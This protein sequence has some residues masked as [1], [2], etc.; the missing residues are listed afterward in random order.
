M[1]QEFVH[2][3]SQ[4]R[5]SG[6]DVVPGMNSRL[7]LVADNQNLYSNFR[8]IFGQVST[9]KSLPYSKVND[10]ALDA[11]ESFCCVP[12]FEVDYV[13]SGEAGLAVLQQACDVKRPYAVVFIDMN[14]CSGWS[15][16]K[17]IEEY[18]NVDRFLQC[19]LCTT[20]L[21][22]QWDVEVESMTYPEHL[23]IL[24][25]PF[26]AIDVQQ[27]AVV[28]THKWV[29][30]QRTSGQEDR[31]FPV[32]VEPTHQLEG[33]D[34]CLVHDS[35]HRR[36]DEGLNIQTAQDLE[37]KN[38]EL[39]KAKDEL[40]AAK[41]HMEN[42]IGSMA[43]TLLVINAD[44]T[45]EAVNR[46]LLMLLGY[47]EEELLQE[48]PSKIFGEEL[49]QGSIMEA[50][51][52][53]GVVSNVETTYLAKN[54]QAIPMAL[55]GSLMKDDRG[56]IQGLV[57]VAQN[58]TERKRLEDERRQFQDQLVETSRRLGMADVATSVLHN[59]GNVLNSINV[60]V[61]IMGTTLR[62]SLVGDVRKISHMLNAHMGDLNA[63]VTHDAKGR[64]VPGYLAQ[65]ADHLIEERQVTLKEL[66]SLVE[67]AEHAKQCVAM[68]Q[69]MVK[70]G[71]LHE[72]VMLV[73]LM[74]QALTI[75]KVLLEKLDGDI[76][77]EFVDTEKVIVDK[78]QTLQILVN[79]IRNSTQAMQ[80]SAHKT[81]TV[82][83]GPAESERNMVQL[84]V[85]DTGVGI[86][87]DQLTHI[88][89]QGFTTKKDGHGFGLH[90]GALLAKNM[91]GSLHV[92]SAG[93]G[94]GATFILTLPVALPPD[95]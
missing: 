50:L 71:G 23:L 42:I 31:A 29:M 75:N 67:S 94:C 59:V 81:L 8:R 14:A 48:C 61:G 28:L 12:C 16:K 33:V 52:F 20:T 51:Y 44:M 57:C 83:I 60:S 7:L 95:L 45:I 91:G 10:E 63:Y 2:V 55:S 4:R 43:D 85:T 38:S 39:A 17:T 3:S 53:Q 25:K 86:P 64:Q 92:R 66:D 78:H 30:S 21:D 32:A 88:F 26:H 15:R 13:E 93:E 70:A 34:M 5:M 73:D 49:T 46:S 74:E 27:L 11:S 76:V 9:A 68:Q 47:K 35:E 58:I 22:C 89:S 40:S 79:L 18:W 19:V 84:E 82:R 54:G 87:A 41:T 56:V 36:R 80:K 72:P 62:Q 69:G 65:L 77:R 6:V 1:S 24:R 90:S 37:R